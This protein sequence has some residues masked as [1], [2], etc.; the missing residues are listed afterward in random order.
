MLTALLYWCHLKGIQKD[1]NFSVL[2]CPSVPEHQKETKW[3]LLKIDVDVSNKTIISSQNN[4]KENIP[5]EEE[6]E[7]LVIKEPTEEDTGNKV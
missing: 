3:S 5:S 7:D 4:V 1:K 6:K 2:L